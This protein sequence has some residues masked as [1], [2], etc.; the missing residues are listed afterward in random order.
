[1]ASSET[2]MN[3][4]PKSMMDYE[5]ILFE[6]T[7]HD[8]DCFKIDWRTVFDEIYHD[9]KSKYECKRLKHVGNRNFSLEDHKLIRDKIYLLVSRKIKS[10][11]VGK[12][13][14]V[15][16]VVVDVVVDAVVHDNNYRDNDDANNEDDIPGS[17]V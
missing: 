8:H 7:N 17:A 4:N 10:L 12:N 2:S 11:F 14:N 16:V 3:M 13:K 15:D 5:S 1:M 6:T 9:L